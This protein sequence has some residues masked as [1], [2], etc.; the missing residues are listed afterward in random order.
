MGNCAGGGRAFT[1][2][3]VVAPTTDTGLEKLPPRDTTDPM[4]SPEVVM[5]LISALD[6]VMVLPPLA[7]AESTGTPPPAPAVMEGNIILT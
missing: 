6:N 2:V 7:I 4:A 5:A 3:N 1:R